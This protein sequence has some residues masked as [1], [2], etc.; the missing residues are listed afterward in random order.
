MVHTQ[1]GMW[2]DH[3]GVR[4]PGEWMLQPSLSPPWAPP[5]CKAFGETDLK[6]GSGAFPR[7]PCGDLLGREGRW[8]ATI[9]GTWQSHRPAQC[10]V[11]GYTSLRETDVQT[12]EGNSQSTQLLWDLLGT[13]RATYKQ[14]SQLRRVSRPQPWSQRH[15]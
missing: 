6:P 2:D 8:A 3:G 9:L 11:H 12:A 14:S 5:S 4:C 13:C 10:E 7:L 1:V 15:T